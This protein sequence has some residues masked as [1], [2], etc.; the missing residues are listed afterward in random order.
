M[1]HEGPDAIEE[2]DLFEEEEDMKNFIVEDDS[3]R[4]RPK[5]SGLV[6]KKAVIFF[7]SKTE[8]LFAVHQNVLWVQKEN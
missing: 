3:V 4:E 2:E 5:R 1:A 7:L 6:R 8:F